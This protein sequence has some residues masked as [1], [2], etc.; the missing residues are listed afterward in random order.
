[1]LSFSFSRFQYWQLAS[2]SSINYLKVK[3]SLHL[4]LILLLLL[5]TDLRHS[6]TTL[7]ICFLS[8]YQIYY[9][10]YIY[11]EL[12]TSLSSKLKHSQQYRT[13][14]LMYI[15]CFIFIRLSNLL[16]YLYLFPVNCIIILK[17]QTFSAVL[18]LEFDVYNL[19]SRTT[20]FKNVSFDLEVCSRY[21]ISG[22]QKK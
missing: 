2:S 5:L 14:N 12:I 19:L 18:N 11:Q 17:I 20:T 13:L 1:M 7:N 6:F 21:Q 22:T 15:T 3:S 8:D 16:F 10:N 4:R 9:S